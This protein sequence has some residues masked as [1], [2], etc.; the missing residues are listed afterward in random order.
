L[1]VRNQLA[2]TVIE[3]TPD[4]PHNVLVKL[5]AGGLILLARITAAAAQ[6]LGLRIG[7]PLWILIKAVSLRAHAQ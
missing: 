4:A 2:G 3:L 1:S 7:Q 6:D 5:D